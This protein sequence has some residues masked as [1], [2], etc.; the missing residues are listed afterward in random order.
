[1]QQTAAALVV[2]RMEHWC[3]WCMASPHPT[4]SRACGECMQG[5]LSLAADMRLLMHPLRDLSI[6]EMN[7]YAAMTLT[8]ALPSG[9]SMMHPIHGHITRFFPATG[10]ASS[11]LEA[12]TS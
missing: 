4:F 9:P 12:T 10:C 1:M 11:F 2:G 5:R 6:P 7:S 8:E 3:P